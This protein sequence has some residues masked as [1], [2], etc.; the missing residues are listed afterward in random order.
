MK[1]LILVILTVLT[2]FGTAL[3]EKQSRIEL[4]GRTTNPAPEVSEKIQMETISPGGAPFGGAEL[5]VRN[6]SRPSLEPYL[7]DPDKA[8]GAAMVV[9]PGGGFMGLAIEREGYAVARWLN[10]RGIAAFVL[11]YRVAPMPADS[12]A[13]NKAFTGVAKEIQNNAAPAQPTVTLLD[14]LPDRLRQAVPVARQDG[15]EAIRYVRRHAAEWRISPHRIGLM[16]FSAGAVAAVD[17]AL[18]ADVDGRPDLIAPVYGALPDATPV[19]SSVPPA[20]IAVAADDGMSSYSLKLYDAWRAAG[21]SAELHVFENGLHGFALINQGKS[22][23]QWL[24]LFDRWLAA[25]G[26]EAR[27]TATENARARTFDLCVRRQ[28]HR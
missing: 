12:G 9:A 7:P 27:S 5:W 19:P 16:G 24:Q 4:P 15:L 20:F 8:T 1:T 11:K 10:Q 23:D 6:V 2:P 17:V 3:A 21:A 14:I 26:F 13:Y 22:S 28:L 25:H 18:K